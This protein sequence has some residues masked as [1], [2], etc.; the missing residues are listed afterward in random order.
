M[1]RYHIARIAAFV[2]PVLNPLIVV[3]RT[4][5]L[6]R[7]LRAQWT[8]LKSRASSRTTKSRRSGS[9]RASVR[10]TES[11]RNRCDV[12]V[13]L[14]KPDRPNSLVMLLAQ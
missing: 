9:E 7:Q 3:A 8:S 14:I 12:E 11:Q 6:R 2:D 4:P 5:A 1:L 13:K 10:R